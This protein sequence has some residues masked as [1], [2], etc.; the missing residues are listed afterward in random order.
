[1][2]TYEIGNPRRHCAVFI[3]ECFITYSVWNIGIYRYQNSQFEDIVE[4]WNRAIT[5]I[6]VKWEYSEGRS[7][8][9]V[10][11]AHIHTCST[12]YV[13]KL[14]EGWKSRPRHSVGHPQRG[15]PP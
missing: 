11:V 1:M 5:G 6:A 15:M 13:S 4:T 7:S 8:T 12:S 14:P 9:Y 2:D 10:L 3:G